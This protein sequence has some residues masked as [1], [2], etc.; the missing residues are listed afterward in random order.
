MF[1]QVSFSVPHLL[2]VGLLL[3]PTMYKCLLKVLYPVR[4]PITTVDCVLLK[5]NK[6]AL[7]ARLG[8][9]TN[10]Q[11]CLCTIKTAPQYQMLVFHPAFYLLI[12]CL[13]T[14]KKGSGPT[15]CWSEPS[16]A[17]LSPISFPCT[18][19]GPGTQ[20][21]PKVCR[22]EISFSAVWHC[23]TKGDVLT[24]WSNFRPAW[25]SEQMLTN[26]SDLSWVSISLTQANITYTS[27]WKTVA[28]F[29]REMLSL[30]SADCT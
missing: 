17:S 3:S 23:H 11:A 2:Q 24:A 28:C 27:A 30:L 1:T 15:N 20:Y 22:V 14:P 19:A 25:L 12:F 13:E 6:W 4:R 7:V 16:L 10:S 5:D 9:E 29:R 18:P 21:N 8:P 26:L